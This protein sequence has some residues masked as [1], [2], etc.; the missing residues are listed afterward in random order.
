MN[1]LD[2]IPASISTGSPINQQGE[3]KRKKYRGSLHEDGTTSAHDFQSGVGR[4]S[5]IELLSSSVPVLL[6]QRVAVSF[7]GALACG[8]TA[9]R[10][11]RVAAEIEVCTAFV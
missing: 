8:A 9:R 7:V 5:V 10:R 4:N 2:A 1:L 6:D 11:A 3:P